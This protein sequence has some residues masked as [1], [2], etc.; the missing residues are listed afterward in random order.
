MIPAEKC[1]DRIVPSFLIIRCYLMD[2]TRGSTRSWIW[3]LGWQSVSPLLLI[4]CLIQRR[5]ICMFLLVQG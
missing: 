3:K 5:S 1:V 4:W 2:W